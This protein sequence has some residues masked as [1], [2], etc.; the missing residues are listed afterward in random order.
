VRFAVVVLLL[1]WVLAGAVAVY[2]LR[3]SRTADAV[4]SARRAVRDDYRR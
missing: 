2:W 4:T 3:H 1:K